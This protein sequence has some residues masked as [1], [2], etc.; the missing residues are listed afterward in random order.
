MRVL[1]WTNEIKKKYLA[2]FLIYGDKYFHN[3][4]YAQE[5][6]KSLKSR[7]FILLKLELKDGRLS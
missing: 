2:Y 7:H 3:I 5:F 4:T 1:L 6:R